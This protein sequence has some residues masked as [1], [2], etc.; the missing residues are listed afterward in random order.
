MGCTPTALEAIEA[1]IELLDPE[2]WKNDPEV[3][4]ALRQDLQLFVRVV[5]ALMVGDDLEVLEALVLLE[6]DS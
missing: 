1:R 3:I 2:R 5:K 4:Q 6:C